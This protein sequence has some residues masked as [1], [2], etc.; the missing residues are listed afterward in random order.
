MQFNMTNVRIY[1]GVVD[2]P[3]SQFHGQPYYWLRCELSNA[4][5]AEYDPASGRLPL[6]FELNSKL[7]EKKW[8]PL[9]T[10]D[11][12]NK[13]QFIISDE[14]KV[15]TEHPG[16]LLLQYMESVT[17]TLPVPMVRVHTRDVFD[18][19]SR[20]TASKGDPVANAQGDVVPV[21]KIS[22]FI[23]HVPD[24]D[25]PNLPFKEMQLRTPKDEVLRGILDRSYKVYNAAP[26]PGPGFAP[27]AP[28]APTN[29]PEKSAE[30]KLAELE[31]K[32][33]NQA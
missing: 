3:G 26:T 18:T 15:K 4:A 16:V 31:A 1:S 23:Q 11:P 2:K 13:G 21:T 5:G 17:E 32:L 6:H 27:E 25:Q 30:E 10:E 33:R 29:T 9:A 22:F 12:N 7:I 8:L 14:E 19:T 20:K 28:Q 24:P